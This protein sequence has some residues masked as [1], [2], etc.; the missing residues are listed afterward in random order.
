[1]V[2]CKTAIMKRLYWKCYIEEQA[3]RAT[4]FEAEKEYP[5]ISNEADIEIEDKGMF[6]CLSKRH[7]NSCNLL[8]AITH[9]ERRSYTASLRV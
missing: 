3:N 2:P 9:V 5:G 4:L 6:F 1:M 7:L 8:R